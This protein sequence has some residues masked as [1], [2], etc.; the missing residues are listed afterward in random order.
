MKIDS[1]YYVNQ[2]KREGSFRRWKSFRHILKL[3]D[4]ST[5]QRF[6]DPILSCFA[7]FSGK[8]HS[9]NY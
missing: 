8:Y 3:W 7:Q 6:V 2:G 5:N 1:Y 9:K 4:Y